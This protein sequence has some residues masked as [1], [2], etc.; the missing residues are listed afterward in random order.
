MPNRTRSKRSHTTPKPRLL[1]PRRNPQINIILQPFIRILIPR[2][3]EFFVILG[4]FE[5][6]GTDVCDAV[7]AKLAGG[8]VAVEGDAGED[9]GSFCHFPDAVVFEAV[10]QAEGL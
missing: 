9:A 3:Q 4:S 6:E 8:G 1:P 5:G 2:L 10:S 7:P